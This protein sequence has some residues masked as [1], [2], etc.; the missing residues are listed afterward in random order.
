MEFTPRQRAAIEHAGGNLQIIACAGSGKTEVVA[1]R[2]AHILQRD[3]EAGLRPNSFVAFTFTDKAAA[4]LKDRIGERVRDRLGEVVGMAELY[5]GTIH[6]FCLDLLKTHI[7]EYLKF[8]VLSDVQRAL[9][10]D[11]NSRQSGLTVATTLDGVPL[12]RF[13][14]T[15]AYCQALDILREDISD[16]TCLINNSVLQTSSAYHTLLRS[17][18]YLDYSEILAVAAHELETDARLH[19]RLRNT[20]KHLIV[21]EYQDINPVQ[22]RIIRALNQLGASLCVVG[23][24][25]Q[26]IYQWRG[27]DVRNIITFRDRY[28]HVTTISLEE[29]F[30][31]STGVIETARDCIALNTVRLPKAMKSVDAQTHHTGDVCAHSFSSPAEEAEFIAET[32]K[33]LHGVAFEDREGARGLSYSD[34][35]VL[36]RTVKGSADP[37]LRAL[38]VAGIPFVVVGMTSLFSTREANAARHTFY[39]LSGANG[40]GESEVRSAWVTAQLGVAAGAMDDA[41]T[42]LKDTKKALDEADDARWAQYSLQRTYLTLLE[43][44]RISE[45]SIPGDRG[46]IVLYN[47]GKFSQAISD[48]EQIHFQSAPR[49]KYESFA[50]FLEHQADRHYAEGWQDNQYASPDAVQV[51]TVHQ[52]KGMQWPVVFLPALIRNRFPSKRGGGKTAWHLLPAT[53]VANASR[54]QGDIEDE[55]R[56]FYVA[57]TRSQKFLFMSW[58]PVAGNRLYQRASDF[59]DAVLGSKWV[60]RPKVDYSERKRL[61]ARSRAAINNVVLTFS[62]LKYFFE[63]PY[64]FK[65]RILYGFNAPLHEALGYGKSLHD[66]L[67][68]VHDRAIRGDIPDANE[69]QSLVATHLHVPFAYPRLRE[70][71]ERS[72]AGII[73]D[74]LQQ[75]REDLGR[76]EYSEKAISLDLGD[77]ISVVG[78]IDLVRRLDTD[79]ISIVDMKTSDRAQAENLTEQ[80][81]HV[82]AIGYQQLTGRRADFVEIYELDEQRRK[83]RAVDDDFIA[84]VEV[85]IKEASRGLRL[86]QLNARPSERACGGCDYQRL[87]SHSACRR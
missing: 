48:F 49:A 35:A 10:V 18:R 9:L 83:P 31:S 79:E 64:Q 69:A 17:K 6:A 77:G 2:I 60:K 26:T 27:S 22:E 51:M 33:A 68:E 74:Y 56:L 34:C 15:Q 62:D 52:A 84:Q 40:V 87:C 41:V 39:F 58:A 55:R 80:Q 54:Y 28:P 71:L 7:P 20:I 38:A 25:D 4:E 11:R 13:I 78:R 30:R 86:N 76:L 59:Y 82:Y 46:E 36:L 73:R 67:A 57:M 12:R 16:A 21:D 47:L 32:I 65:L 81:L 1:Q 8:N 63:C 24:D 66:C 29:N 61:P 75:R 72:A 23:D 42:F 85:D 44:L 37:I 14:D 70:Q 53:A 43:K 3:W 50:G 45:G 5:V 19:A